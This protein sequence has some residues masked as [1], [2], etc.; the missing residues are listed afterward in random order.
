MDILSALLLMT[1]LYPAF[2]VAGVALSIVVSTYLQV[3]Y[4]IWHSAKLINVHITDLVPF[5]FLAKL[6]FGLAILYLCFFF[7]KYY[8]SQ[9]QFLMIVFALTAILIGFALKKLP[10]FK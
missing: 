9:I 4:Y 1:L 2:G 6:F 10:F 8:F 3:F 7:L 5:T